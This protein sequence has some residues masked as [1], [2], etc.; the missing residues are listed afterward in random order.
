MRNPPT[1]G[2]TKQHKKI[3]WHYTVPLEL[4]TASQSSCKTLRGMPLKPIEQKAQNK[5]RKWMESQRFS[6]FLALSSNIL[7]FLFRHTTQIKAM[8]VFCH[9]TNP[10]L[11]L[12]KPL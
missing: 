1:K 10:L 7:A 4:H 9:K 6:E 12:P 5:A 2:K 3:T 11:D 8:H